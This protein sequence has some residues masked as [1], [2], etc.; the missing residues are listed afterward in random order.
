MLHRSALTITR[1]RLYADWANNQAE[2]GTDPVPY[3]DDLPR[4]VYLIPPDDSPV[5]ASELLDEWWEAIFEEELAAWS[6]DESTW[7]TARTRELFDLWFEAELTDTVID[8][9][10]DEPLTADDVAMAAMD[11]VLRH[12]AWCGLELEPEEARSVG[13]EVVARERL[14]PWEGSVL[15]LPVDD[16][17]ALIGILTTQDSDAAAVG[18][19][20]IFRACTSRCEKR[21]RHEAPRALGRLLDLLPQ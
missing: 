10:P 15:P 18:D 2:E 1:K 7:P 14:A 16:E 21:I 12:C 8:L 20:L 13:L 3:S 19:D 5:D 17:R 11:E 6:E 9:A 4:T